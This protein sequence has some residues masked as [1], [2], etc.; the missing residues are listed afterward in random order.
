M[1]PV[2]LDT[3]LQ[4]GKVDSPERVY[5]ETVLVVCVLCIIMSAPTGAMIIYFSGP[6]LLTKTVPGP[7]PHPT[8]G[9]RPSMRDITVIDEGN[10]T[11]DL[12]R[13]M[14]RD[15]ERRTSRSSSVVPTP[16]PSVVNPPNPSSL[17]IP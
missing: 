3:V 5:A 8:H 7:P 6:R 14:S 16:R 13:R 15:M 2:A 1:A 10:E 11:C 12:E 4:M 17:Q 9:R